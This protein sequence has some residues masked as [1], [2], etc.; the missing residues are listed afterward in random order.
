MNPKDHKDIALLKRLKTG[1]EKAFRKIYLKYHKQLYSVAVRYLRSRELAED[2]VHDVFVKLWN[3]RT[4]LD[5]KGSLKG[6]IFTAVKNHVLNMISSNKRK[7]KRNIAFTYEQEN[8]N[9]K[10]A[11][12]IVL[13][14]Y[15]EVYQAAIEHLP[16]KRREVFELRTRD[17]LTNKEAAAYLEVSVHTVK[18]QYYKATNFIREYVNK[19]MSMQTGS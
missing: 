14:Q 7:L 11:N 19:N 18:S 2:A 17:G 1:D 6:F 3:H 12:I 16:K 13:S 4:E 9:T 8:S 15:H 5:A 10:A